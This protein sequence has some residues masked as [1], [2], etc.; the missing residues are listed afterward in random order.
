MLAPLKTADGSLRLAP[1]RKQVF[2]AALTR[3]ATCF[4]V[5]L[6]PLVAHFTH[7]THHQ[8]PG[9]GQLCEYVNGGAHGV[10]VGVVG[11]INQAQG[12]ALNRDDHCAGAPLDGH[13]GRQA[14]RDA[15]Q[16]HT[17]CQRARRCCQCILDVVPA[18]NVQ[19]KFEWP[20]WRSSYHLPAI[21]RPRGAGGDIGINL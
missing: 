20:G 9:A 14:G 17:G 7:I 13:K 15:K 12:L 5:E 21:A 8:Q 3:I 11:V 4:F 2:N 6:W 19:G 18:R 10:R 1:K 16:W